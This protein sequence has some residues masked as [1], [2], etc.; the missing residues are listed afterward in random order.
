MTT[1]I[2]KPMAGI[3]M[4][5]RHLPTLSCGPLT[6]LVLGL[7]SFAVAGDTKTT[8]PGPSVAESPQ[9]ITQSKV[10]P[11]VEIPFQSGKKGKAMVK[12][13]MSHDNGDVVVMNDMNSEGDITVDPKTGNANSSTQVDFRSDVTGSVTGVDPNDTVN[14]PS[15]ST[16]TVTG[17]GGTVN[18]S[19]TG[20]NA[21]VTNDGTSTSITVK[22]PGGMTVT[23]PP[24]STAIVST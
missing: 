21:T 3:P 16:A 1:F 22:G 14:L 24:G 8:P 4:L 17:S 12:P 9:P 23:I 20:V 2:T 18:V 6:L 10:T 5:R 13:G 7:Q 15:N 11:K 19:G